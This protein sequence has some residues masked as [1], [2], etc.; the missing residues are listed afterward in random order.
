MKFLFF[1]VHPAKFHFHKVQINE[2]KKRG[3]QVDI[4]I[5]KKDILEELVISE[6]W[7]YTNIYPE[8]RKIKFLHVY[9]GALIALF[10]TVYR[11]LKYTKGKKYDLF[12]GDLL[13]V[14]GRIKGV[15]SL[16]AT[17]NPLKQVPEQS[18]FLSTATHIIS[19]KANDLG[20]FNKKTINYPGYKALAHLHPNHFSPNI[21]LI[22]KNLRNKQFFIIRCVGFDATHDIGKKG[23]DDNL[24]NEL[25]KILNPYGE[26]LISS[27]RE[28]EPHLE[29]YK[30][31]IDKNLISHYLSYANLVIADSATMIAEAAFLGT[32]AIEFE[33]YFQ[34]VPQMQELMNIYNLIHC[35]DTSEKNKL[36]NKLNELL[37]KDLKKVYHDRR[38]RMIKEFCDLSGF[39]VW[40]YE[41]YPKSHRN[42]KNDHNIFEKFK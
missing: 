39:L 40:Y 28:L 35:F 41:N 22:D 24:L 42:Y 32:P 1:L 11:L 3:H 21:S 37:L 2:L 38:D 16:Y 4:I 25:I 8:G 12:I 7:D 26:V 13:T 31:E 23:I 34:E 18:I 6:G 33:G 27:E 14:V 36:F 19:P 10:R 29:K 15:K 5:I 30:M 20:F 9:L 17:D